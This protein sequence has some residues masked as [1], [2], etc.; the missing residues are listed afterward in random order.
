[1]A[2]LPPH[3]RRLFKS[4]NTSNFDFNVPIITNTTSTTI[5]TIKLGEDPV[6]VSVYPSPAKDHLS[7]EVRPG[8]QVTGFYLVNMLGVVVFE[9]LQPQNNPVQ[10]INIS[11]LPPGVYYLVVNSIQWR[12]VR[13]IVILK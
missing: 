1:M 4:L 9:S 2:A 11:T 7:F 5:T 6:L 12:S 8:R 13:K 3:V 10:Q